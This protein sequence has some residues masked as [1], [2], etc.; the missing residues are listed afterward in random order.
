[1]ILDFRDA[2]VQQPHQ[3]GQTGT[4]LRNSKIY[5][6]VCLPYST[7]TCRPGLKPGPRTTGRRLVRLRSGQA[8]LADSSPWIAAS[9]RPG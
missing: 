2:A 5:H 9:R 6:F 8:L 1:M 7:Q 3:I 4:E